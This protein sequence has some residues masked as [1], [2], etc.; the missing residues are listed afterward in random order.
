M[1]VD[2]GLSEITVEGYCRCISIALRRIRKFIPDHEDIRQYV[3]WLMKERYSYSH[4]A[5]LDVMRI[6]NAG[7]IRLSPQILRITS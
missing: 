2:K 3:L 7:L 4:Y 5:D 6:L 1:M